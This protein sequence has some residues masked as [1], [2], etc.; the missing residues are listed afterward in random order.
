MLNSEGFLVT[1]DVEKA[2]DSL[3]HDF[4][5]S[6]LR[7][8]E[9][10]KYFITWI[11][12]LLKYQLSCVINGRTATQYFNLERGVCQS[13]PISAY[14][15][16]LTLEILFLLIKKHPEKKVQKYLS[17]VSF[18]LLTQ[19]M[20]RFFWKIHNSLHTYLNFSILFPFFQD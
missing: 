10:G 6:V 17:I 5:I 19:M 14:L 3:G 15:F 4:L 2:F 20:Q 13:D 7:E 1:M 9:S 12:T 11:E 16:I 8:F 18:I